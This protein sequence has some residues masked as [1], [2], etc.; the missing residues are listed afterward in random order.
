M[1]AKLS[2]LAFGFVIG[3]GLLTAVTIVNHT[4]TM[5]NHTTLEKTSRLNGT[6]TPAPFQMERFG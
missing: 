6:V 2:Y 1:L 4:T 3:A 5:A